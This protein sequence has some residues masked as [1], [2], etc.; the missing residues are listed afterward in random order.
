MLNFLYKDRPNTLSPVPLCIL[1]RSVYWLSPLTDGGAL[2][3]LVHS[4]GVDITLYLGS[5]WDT[6]RW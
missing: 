3:V 1:G 6:I 2:G 5:E 4:S